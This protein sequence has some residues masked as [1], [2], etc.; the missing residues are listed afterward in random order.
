MQLISFK[1][2]LVVP[3]E[4]G[5]RTI[6]V[7]RGVVYVMHDVEVDGAV[8]AG[9]AA[10]VR[11]LPPTPAR[12]ASPDGVTG[13]LVLPFIGGLG[14]ALCLLPVLETLRRRSPGLRL[15]IA[16]P[17][18][19]AEVFGLADVATRLA[20]HPLTLPGWRR[21]AR[22]LSMECVHETGQ[23][24]GRALTDT[25][26]DAVG[27]APDDPTV[28]LAPPAGA[29]MPR[30]DDDGP[31][32]AVAVG[33][34]D[35][36]RA[37]PRPHL[38][39]LLDELTA[40][41]RRCVLVGHQSPAGWE[42]ASRPAVLDLRDATPR[43][44]DLAAVLARA[45][46]VIAHDSFVMHLGAALGRPTLSLFAPTSP[47]LAPRGAGCVSIGSDASCAPCHDATAACP[48]GHD[49]CVAWDVPALAPAAVAARVETLLGSPAAPRALA[50]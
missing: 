50:A 5:R 3:V 1:R 33:D 18:G 20:A 27:L 47:G 14:D 49:R 39:R 22:Y 31:F 42:L 29:P 21:H 28:R 41:G 24:P 40:A 32:V 17:P 35:S 36:L 2:S 25:F 15:T 37:Y 8:R 45:E 11:P 30:L 38:E 26:A 19:P 44:V 4:R 10:S 7:R 34:G 46:A 48:R 6:P 43:V 9:V 13:E 16:T 23:A 12:L